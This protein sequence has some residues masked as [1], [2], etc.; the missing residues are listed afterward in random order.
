[1]LIVGAKGHALEV[2]QCLTE[3]EREYAVFFDDVTQNQPQKVFGQYTLLRTAAE[4]RA[5]LASS[6]SR[7]VLGLGGPTLRQRL[8][9]QFIEWGGLLTTITASTAV[10]GP[11]TNKLG[12]GLNIMHYSMIAPDVCLGEGVLLNAGAAVHHNVEVGAYCE[13]SPGARLLGRCRLG[14]RC[15]IGALAVVL[16]DIVIGDEAVVGAGAVVTR[17]V[18]AGSTVTGVPARPIWTR[19]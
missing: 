4:A 16:P 14:Q 5:Y 1:M 7:F 9:T 13:I 11:H 2:F 10:V 6:D 8:A 19:G 12:S 17:D 3:A 15:R 18:A